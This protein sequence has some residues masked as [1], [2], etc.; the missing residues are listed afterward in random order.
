MR[1]N[2][3][4]QKQVLLPEEVLVKA[5]A[6]ARALGLTL[7]EYVQGLVDQDVATKEDDP[8]LEPVPKEVDEAWEKDIA[9]TETQE[10]RH[11]RPGART[12][13]ELIKRLDAEAARLSDYEGN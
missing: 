13:D 3:H 6:R 11:P 8:W 1:K 5:E 9:E 7:A 2:R 4:V 12:A 10:K